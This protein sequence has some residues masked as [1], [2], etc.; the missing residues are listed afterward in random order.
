MKLYKISVL[1]S[2]FLLNTACL[3]DDTEE[4]KEEEKK[5][6]REYIESNN[7]TTEPTS[8]G[9][10]YIELEEGDSIS[11]EYGNYVRM[12]YTSRLIDETI[13][14]T[15]YEDVAKENGLYDSAIVYGP[16]KFQVGAVIEGLNEGLTYMKTGG[17][18]R[19]II[20]SDLALGSYAVGDIPA[21]ST[22]IYDV[23]LLEVITNPE[24]HESQLLEVYLDT[25]NIEVEPQESGLYYIELEKG[26]GE[27]P[28]YRDF[29]HVKYTGWLIDGRKFDSG[30]FVM[31]YGVTNVI[32]GWYEGL[33]L[34]NEGGKAKL[35]IPS[36]LAYGSNGS[37]VIP[38]YSTLVFEVELL[39]ISM[40]E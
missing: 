18:A 3:K 32:E 4:K 21:Y 35:I 34:M 39:E 13:F 23:E 33:G 9:L 14:Y 40:D 1:L 19:L 27:K 30:E 16:N 36:N 6:L 11:P 26:D 22:L 10:Y 28:E 29:L 25:S 2:L 12:N 24:L 15:T 31:Q 38:P 20:P 8:S 5:K 37:D 7:I 17:K